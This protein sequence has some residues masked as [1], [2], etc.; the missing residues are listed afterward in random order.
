ML[1]EKLQS[2]EFYAF[3]PN[4]DNRAV[5]GTHIRDVFC[6]EEGQHA[7]SF[8]PDGPCTVLEMLIG[9]AYR[10]E[11]E[12]AQSKYEKSPREWFWILVDNLGLTEYDNHFYTDEVDNHVED[13]ITCLL[14]RHYA[15]NGEGGLFPLHHARLDQ[16]K[17]E[18][19]Y[20]MS[21]YIIENY[22]V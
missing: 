20:Q 4:D 11:F 8:C 13:V 1:L 15:S 18:I 9:L 5:D 3:V 14:E 6:E 7:L 12:T 10:L 16:R 21:A 22:P 2:M 19:W 17:V